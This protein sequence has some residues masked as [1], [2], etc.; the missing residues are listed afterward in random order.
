MDFYQKKGIPQ[1]EFF[2]RIFSEKLK[3][4]FILITKEVFIVYA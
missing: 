2:A 3:W 1:Q 4:S